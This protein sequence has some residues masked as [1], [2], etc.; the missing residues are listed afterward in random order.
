M[1]QTSDIVFVLSGGASNT[2]PS[3]SLGD[4]PSSHQISAGLNNLFSDL[5]D[6]QTQQGYTDYRCFYIFNNSATDNFF[7]TAIWIESVTAGSGSIFLG[8]NTQND[9]QQI[10]VTGNITGG[11]L[12][13]IYESN[14]VRWDWSADLATWGFNLQVALNSITTPPLSGV[15]VTASQLGQ[16]STFQ[17]A[18]Q[19]EDGNRFQPIL[20]HG[21]ISTLLG[22]TAVTVGKIVS[23]SPINVIAD[24]IDVPTTPPTGINFRQPSY[25][26]PISLG[27]L[28]YTEGF[29]VWV[30]RVTEAGAGAVP[31]AGFVVRYKGTPLS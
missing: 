1:I 20:G 13:I 7:N 2:D 16:N 19:G 11:Y 28:R 4:E 9:V 15:S 10:V 22:C 27:T 3:K 12:N 8:I 29:P 31:N 6:T 25:S 26:S 21:D 14:V 23:G 24:S 17:V 30:Q 18:F 5:T